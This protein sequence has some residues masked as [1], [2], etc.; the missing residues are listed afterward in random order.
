[1]ACAVWGQQAWCPYRA[2]SHAGFIA[3]LGPFIYSR[4]AF[5]RPRNGLL[6]VMEEPEHRDAF[7]SVR[8]RP[9]FAAIRDPEGN[10]RRGF[11]VQWI[12]VNGVLSC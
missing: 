11:R 12:R 3:G 8:D 5:D 4:G 9:V 7:A 2:G 10:A 1:M 6:R